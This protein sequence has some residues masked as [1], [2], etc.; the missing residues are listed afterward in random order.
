MVESSAPGGTGSLDPR[1]GPGGGAAFLPGP[2]DAAAAGAFAQRRAAGMGTLTAPTTRSDNEAKYRSRNPVVRALVGSFLRQV[3]A[4]V[5]EA[6]PRRVLEVGCGEGIVLEYLSRRAA[7]VRF[8]GVELDGV[9]V[10]RARARCPDAAL[11]RDRKST[12]LNS[13]H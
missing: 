6:R 10:R 1:E 2:T 9:A 13:S 7:G 12:R 11:M 4:A 8:E 3:A 5:A